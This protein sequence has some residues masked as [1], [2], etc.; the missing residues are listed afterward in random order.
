MT[1]TFPSQIR[2]WDLRRNVVNFL[3]EDDGKPMQCAISMEALVDH[4]GATTRTRQ[5]CL[6]AFDRWRA[7]IQ[8][9]AS[10]KHEAQDRTG[11]VLLRSADFP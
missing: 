6:A 3:G 8:R 2:G 7:A 5:S 11:L 1:L 9:K 4:F 10:D